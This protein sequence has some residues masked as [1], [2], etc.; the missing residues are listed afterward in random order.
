MHL[1]FLFFLFALLGLVPR[2]CAQSPTQISGLVKDAQT[3]KGIPFATVKLLPGNGGAVADLAGHF[4]LPVSGNIRSLEVSSIGYQTKALPFSAKESPLLIRLQPAKEAELAEVKIGSPMKKIRRLLNAAIAN[5]DRHNPEKR[6]E[7][8]CSV[9]Y[10]MIAD[11]NM[12]DLAED[13]AMREKIERF[14]E[15][16]HLLV[17]ETYSRRS[18]R[19]PACRKTSW[20]PGFPGFPHRHSPT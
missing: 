9:Y 10:K 14:Q 13:S 3:N 16:Q 17:A 4:M 20:L 8:Q 1:R 6:P 12:A 19:R 7:Y 5:R 2:V 18:F 11:V 15:S